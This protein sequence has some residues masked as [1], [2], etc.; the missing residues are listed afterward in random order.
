V[1]SLS[2]GR[3]AAAQ[4]GLFTYKSVPVIF[5]PP[6]NIIFIF[7]STPMSPKRYHPFRFSYQFVC[8]SHTSYMTH[9]MPDSSSKTWSFQKTSSLY[10]QQKSWNVLVIKA[11]H[12]HQVSVHI[13][14]CLWIIL[15]RREILDHRT[16]NTLR[17]VDR[18]KRLW[19][20]RSITSPRC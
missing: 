9:I 12:Q 10:S 18:A 11:I 1:A 16:V 17:N 8:N 2:Q 4:C 19:C 14:S 7:L 5:E 3:T 13:F 20:V 15:G 6:C